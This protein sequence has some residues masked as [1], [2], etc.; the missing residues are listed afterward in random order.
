MESH[1][2]GIRRAFG[3]PYSNAAI[4]KTLD[5]ALEAGC[6]RLDLFFMVG[7]KGQTYESV[8][9]TVDYSRMLLE[10]Y[11]RQGEKRV[12]P[13]ISPLAPFLDPGSQA[14]EEPE[15]HG[16]RL[17]A[18]TLEEHRQALLAPSW[19]Y[20]LN[21]ETVWMN[22]D[23]IVAATY[24]AGQRMNQIKG[25]FGVIDPQVAE[26]TDRR[27]DRARQLIADIDKIVTGPYSAEERQHLLQDL[28][29]QVDNANL[30]TVCDK[31]ELEV[32]MRGTRIN[33]LQAAALVVSDWWKDRTR[34]L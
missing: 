9:G 27:I 1:D 18:R 21:Y 17:F 23:Q 6:Q 12:I 3:R 19:K 34:S 22:R 20:V 31:R 15:K 33:M 16:Y 24:E 32:A 4:E 25:E 5:E 26:A 28:K 7:L 29:H 13:F 30:S 8:M 11:A 10:R 2:E 14:F